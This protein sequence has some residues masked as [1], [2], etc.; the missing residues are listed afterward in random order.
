MSNTFT[1]AKRADL[2]SGSMST[3]SSRACQDTNALSKLAINFSES[4]VSN[5]SSAAIASISGS[6][7]TAAF[8]IDSEEIRDA[9]ICCKSL[10]S[11]PV[12]GSRFSIEP[13]CK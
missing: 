4:A 8:S 10:Y 3:L 5:S 13:K 6:R 9:I 11:A 2:T 1:A 7:A 12:T